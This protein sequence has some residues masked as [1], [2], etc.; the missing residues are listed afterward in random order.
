ML[1]DVTI[2]VWIDV[3]LSDEEA[4]NIISN[5][6]ATNTEVII[7]ESRLMIMFK[8]ESLADAIAL[9]SSTN[10]VNSVVKVKEIR[11][12]DISNVIDPNK[13][14]TLFEPEV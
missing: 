6:V 5:G 9:L 14:E 8:T 12:I 13:Y 2:V 7:T 3:P 11:E 1:D 4:I 10:L